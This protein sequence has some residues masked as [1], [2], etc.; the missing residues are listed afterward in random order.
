MAVGRSCRREWPW[1]RSVEQHWL[2]RRGELP[3]V[4]PASGGGGGRA[5]A[6]GR[7]RGEPR[8]SST[9]R[10]GRAPPAARI[11]SAGRADELRPPRGG[12]GRLRERISHRGGGGG[13]S[14]GRNGKRRR[15]RSTKGICLTEVRGR[16][17]PIEF[18]VCHGTN[19][20][21]STFSVRHGTEAVSSIRTVRTISG[22]RK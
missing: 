19:E 5:P 13:S 14:L 20:F 16:T 7:R 22:H 15:R 11:S 4:A 18:L 17:T 6:S 9:W 21:S 10:R 8:Q 2:E 1:S 3:H 12:C